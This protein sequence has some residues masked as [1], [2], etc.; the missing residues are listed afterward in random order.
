MRE[1]NC[2]STTLCIKNHAMNSW[3]STP[4]LHGDRPAFNR[5]SHDTTSGCADMCHGMIVRHLTEGQFVVHV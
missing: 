4:G 3:G 2:P 5:H 1:K